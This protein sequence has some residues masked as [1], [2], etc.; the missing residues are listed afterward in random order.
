MTRL[1][2]FLKAI[3]LIIKNPWLLNNVINDEKEQQRIFEKKYG[4]NKS[5]PC[6]DL[7][8]L[9]PDFKETVSPFSFRETTIRYYIYLIKTD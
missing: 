6:I 8:T 1:F 4:A 2:K 9:F 3:G 7:L 5:L